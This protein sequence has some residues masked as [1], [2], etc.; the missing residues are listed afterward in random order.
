MQRLPL[1]SERRTWAQSALPRDFYGAPATRHTPSSARVVGRVAHVIVE[2]NSQ[3]GPEKTEAPLSAA[4]VLIAIA[5][6]AVVTKRVTALRHTR[7]FIVIYVLRTAW[8]VVSFGSRQAKGGAA[9]FRRGV[10]RAR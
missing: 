5:H 1:L 8:G 9:A 6:E 10:G 4:S 3:R 7:S 2:S